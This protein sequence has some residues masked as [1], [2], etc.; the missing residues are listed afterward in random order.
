[1]E[2]VSHG[3]GGQDGGEGE[4]RGEE[5]N[6]GWRV[7]KMTVNISFEFDLTWTRH[8]LEIVM[9]EKYQENI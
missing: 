6:Q 7:S 5:G 2:W 9:S 1:M 8:T 3:C 4:G